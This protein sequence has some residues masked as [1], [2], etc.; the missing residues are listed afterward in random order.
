MD[1][2]GHE[3]AE[4]DCCENSCSSSAPAVAPK[5]SAKPDNYV[6]TTFSVTGMDCADEVGAIQRALALPQVSSVHANIMAGKVAISHDPSLTIESL[7]A[8]IN[9]TGVRVSGEETRSFYSDNS[10]RVRLV[11]ASG[12]LLLLGLALE[13]WMPASRAAF[14]ATFIASG[15]LAGVIIFPKAARALR[16]GSLDMNVLMTTAVIGAFAIQQYSEAA[17]VIF[18]FAL[19]ELL[20]AFSV[21]RARRAIREVLSITPQTALLQR[22]DGST[23]AIPVEE[24]KVGDKFQVRPG[25]RVPLDGRVVE[26]ASYV[27][28]APL[29]GE[30]IP[31]AKEPGDAVF[32]GTINDRGLLLVESTEL[33]QE[34]KIS[35]VIRMVEE[36]QAKKAPSQRF[37]DT[38]ARYYTPSVTGMAILVFLLPPLALG[39]PWY[40]WFYRSLVFL[41][42]ACPCALVIATPVAIVSGLTALAR[43]GILVKGGASLEALGALKA[44]ALDKTGTVTEGKPKVKTYKLFNGTADGEFIRIAASLE[45]QS[46]HPLAQAIVTYAQSKGVLFTRASSFQASHGRGGSGRL[47]GHDYFVG[48]HAFAHEIGACNTELEQYLEEL[49]SQALSVVVVGHCAHDQCGAEAIGVFGLGDLPKENTGEAIAALRRAG[50]EK[51]EILSGDNQR[52]VDTIAKQ[53][54]VDAGHGDL[55][56][57]DKASRIRKLKEQYK[58]VGM[59]GDGI[60]DAPALAEATVGIAMGAIGSD[61]AIETADVALMKDDLGKLAEAISQGKNVVKMIRFNIGFAIAAKA[62]FFILTLLGI[63]NLWMA[64]AADMGASL[65]VIFNSLRLLKNPSR[66]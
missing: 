61:T 20:E 14:I 51:I 10:L 36:A 54:H 18:L 33:Y 17:S 38:F 42:I 4:H 64:V 56:P 9:S 55:L 30:S 47:D 50:I 29:T 22:Q 63:S 2:E 8:R 23:S 45:S 24:F 39:A 40:P 60:N 27:N 32:A 35:Q 66:T 11:A 44:I 48:N 57:S 19:A 15:A 26:G 37:V 58:H 6:S 65:L 52:T 31:V 34:T 53:L 59:V 28:Q 12:A 43:R 16:L 3:K 13:W 62:A 7:K 5:P 46:S 21:D 49:E 25:E 1:R 41:V